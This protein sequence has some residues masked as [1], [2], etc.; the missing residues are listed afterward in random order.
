[1]ATVTQIK[2]VALFIWQI[3]PTQRHQTQISLP[4]R[5]VLLYLSFYTRLIFNKTVTTHLDYL[6]ADFDHPVLK[7]HCFRHHGTLGG[8]ISLCVALKMADSLFW[9]VSSWDKCR[10]RTFPE[11]F[12]EHSPSPVTFVIDN[13]E[14]NFQP[15]LHNAVVPIRSRIRDLVS[16]GI[17]VLKCSQFCLKVLGLTVAFKKT[18]IKG[19]ITRIPTGTVWN[20]GVLSL[21]RAG[22]PQKK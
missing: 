16:I 17:N 3:T 5:F 21:N 13:S 22:P 7:C 18:C 9:L 20:Q 1:M 12:E 14:S 10:V 11:V 8:L 2:G 15:Y 6:T 4:S 19:T